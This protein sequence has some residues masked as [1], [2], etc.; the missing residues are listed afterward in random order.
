MP[1]AAPPPRH[2]DPTAEGLRVHTGS[3]GRSERKT[4][5][6]YSAEHLR[7]PPGVTPY[8]SPKPSM[9]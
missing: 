6:T 9:C 3:D 5:M 7:P 2:W 4:E 1:S 8:E